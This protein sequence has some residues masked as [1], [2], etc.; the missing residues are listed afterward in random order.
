M[1]VLRDF[2]KVKLQG[3]PH[4]ILKRINAIPTDCFIEV[5]KGDAVVVF[6]EHTSPRARDGEA[7]I[8]T[9]S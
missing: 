2:I 3:L 8:S 6:P 4:V 5:P 9:K 1:E 7:L